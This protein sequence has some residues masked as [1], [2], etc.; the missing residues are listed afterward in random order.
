MNSG[1]L[2]AIVGTQVDTAWDYVSAIIGVV[3]PFVLGVSILF[4]VIYLIIRVSR[5]AR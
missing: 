3:W 1:T 2:Q 5:G 4:G